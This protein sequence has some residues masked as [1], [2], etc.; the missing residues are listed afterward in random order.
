MNNKEITI[1]EYV[2]TSINLR[3][4]YL[5]KLTDGEIYTIYKDNH[6]DYIVRNNRSIPLSK[7]VCKCVEESIRKYK[8]YGI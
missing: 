5:I 1:D 2:F 4:G 7:E 3:G 8:K 6:S